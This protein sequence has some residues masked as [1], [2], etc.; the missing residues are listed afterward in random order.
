[1][2][3]EPL[4]LDLKNILEALGIYSEEY[5]N[6]ISPN[7][8]TIN[9]PI[10]TGIW[11]TFYFL[12]ADQT[13]SKIKMIVPPINCEKNLLI[14][15]HEHAHAYELYQHLGKRYDIDIAAHEKYASDKE[16]EYIKRKKK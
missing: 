1:M 4:P 15:I 12:G 8:K 5:W 9:C 14:N 7:I 2:S 16:K 3:T 6:Y 10:E 11:G 13:I